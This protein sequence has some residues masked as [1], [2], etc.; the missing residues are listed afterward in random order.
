MLI[1]KPKLHSFST[2]PLKSVQVSLPLKSVQVYCTEE[3]VRLEALRYMAHGNM[4]TF[5]EQLQLW[6]RGASGEAGLHVERFEKWS[7]QDF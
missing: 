4:V 7:A 5:H 1:L 2:L 6:C 3:S